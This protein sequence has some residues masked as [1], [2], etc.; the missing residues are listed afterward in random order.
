MSRRLQ[1]LPQPK[2][3]TDQKPNSEVTVRKMTDEEYAQ[4]AAV[5]PRERDVMAWKPTRR[6]EVGD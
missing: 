2:L 3:E 5:K 6:K 1:P 4:K